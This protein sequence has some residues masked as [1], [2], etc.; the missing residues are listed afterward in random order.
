MNDFL[1]F[2]LW[3]LAP[4]LFFTVMLLAAV[5]KYGGGG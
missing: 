5:L 2:Y 4:A 1:F 3:M